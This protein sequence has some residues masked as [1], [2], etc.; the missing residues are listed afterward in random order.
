MKIYERLVLDVESGDILEELSYDY[1]GDV[2]ECKG[3]KSAPKVQQITPASSTPTEEE[4]E[5]PSQSE[6][7][8]KE[9]NAATQKA[10]DAASSAVET[11]FTDEDEESLLG[12]L[13]SK[14]TKTL[15]R[16]TLLG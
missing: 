1:Y 3:G 4:E 5:T 13:L 10:E 8:A 6:D 12:A 16:R 14:N 11:D 2:A 9:R 7:D 15:N